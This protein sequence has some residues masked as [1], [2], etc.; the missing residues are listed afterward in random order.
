[1]VNERRLQTELVQIRRHGL[2]KA[3]F[4]DTS[5]NTIELNCGGGIRIEAF[6]KAFGGVRMEAL[7][8]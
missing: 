1:M 3:R 2:D 8:E 7:V 6:G 4:G 5:C